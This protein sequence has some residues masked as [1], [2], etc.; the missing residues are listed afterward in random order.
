MRIKYKP[1]LVIKALFHF[2][3]FESLIWNRTC[4]L[5]LLVCCD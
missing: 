1:K 3:L 2:Y 5:S 4:V